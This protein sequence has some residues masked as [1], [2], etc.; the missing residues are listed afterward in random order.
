MNKLEKALFET[1]SIKIA[2]ADKQFW[3]TSGTIGPYFVNTHF[4]Y[5]SEKDAN[6]LLS[7]IDKNTADKFKFAN[8]LTDRI[9]DF[10][11]ANSLYKEVIDYF[12]LKFKSEEKFLNAGYIT[13]G[14]RRD[15]FFSVIAAYLTG[16]KHL[17][18]FKD[19]SVCDKEKI[20]TDIKGADVVHISDLVTQASSYKRAW[21][22]AIKNINGKF[23]LNAS[24]VDRDEGGKF[25]FDSNN[26]VDISAVTINISFLKMLLENKIIN[27]KQFDLI[28]EF[29]KDPI[30]YGK[31]YLSE[32]KNFLIN[33]LSDGKS[34]SKTERCIKENPYNM[35]F[36]EILDKSI[37][38]NIK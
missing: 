23:I 29:K 11:K 38:S 9:V 19:L 21:I 3:Y 20:I 24:I 10:Y 14:E 17:F 13:G 26:I 37:I 2:D 31:N 35:D 8:E 5:G 4:L 15:W 27:Q 30:S 12:I 36:S 7:F 25:F 18:I 28:V 1:G 33:S 6:E 32:N 22:P 16:K 34:R